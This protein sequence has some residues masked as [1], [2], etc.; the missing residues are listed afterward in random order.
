MKTHTARALAA[1]FGAVAMLAASASQASAAEPVVAYPLAS[2]AAY[3]DYLAHS[4]EEGALEGLKQF[5]I[6]TPDEQ[7]RFLG[8]LQDPSLYK[9]FLTAD[10]EVQNSITALAENTS[11]SVSFRN[12]D[13]TYES[14]STVSGVAAAARGPLPRGEHKVK[15]S[16]KLKILGIPVVELKIWVK[17]QSNGRDITK[18][19]DAD[20]GKTNISGT[21]SISKEK[22]KTSMGSQ[23]FCERGGSC[24]GGHTAIGSIVW[25]GTAIFS[26]GAFQIDKVQKLT[27]NVYGSGQSSLKNA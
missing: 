20:G 11:Q 22:P 27:A 18:V 2:P 3:A 21:V 23:Q 7:N 25:N 9:D 6:L 16:N 15:R 14:E 24:V 1:A 4:D 13:V 12:G 26:G 5:R 19:I 8:Y 10:P 17:F